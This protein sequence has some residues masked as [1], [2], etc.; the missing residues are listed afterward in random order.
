MKIYPHRIY[1]HF[2]GTY[3]YVLCV[4]QLCSQEYDGGDFVVYQSIDVNS[5]VFVRPIREWSDDVSKDE[6][7]VTGQGQRFELVENIE[8]MLSS[9]PTPL[10]VDELCERGDRPVALADLPEAMD[11]FMHFDYVTAKVLNEGCEDEDLYIDQAFNTEEE[12]VNAMKRAQRFKGEHKE[13]FKR[14]YLPVMDK[15]E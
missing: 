7:N 2:V 11:K 10:L 13:V 12:A 14:V 15:P 5:Q 1:R 6:C 4:G 8:N 3:F 9:V